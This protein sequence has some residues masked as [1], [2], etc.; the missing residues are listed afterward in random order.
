MTPRT[1]L[2][3]GIEEMALELPRTACERLLQ[4]IALLAKWNRTYNLTAIRDPLGMVEQHLLDSLAVLPHLPLP[5][6]GARVADAGSGAGLPGLPL[7]LA[8]PQ[9]RVALLEANQK[10]AA[11]LRQV[12]IELTLDNVEVHAVRVES[13]QPAS[14]FALVISRA[15]AH[16]ADFIAA[17]RHLVAPGG[18]LAAMKGKDP[19]AEVAELPADV[20]CQR[21]VRVRPPFGDAERHLV[22][23]ELRA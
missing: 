20:R 16:L 21:I 9:W 22:L 4:Y 23:C 6:S 12:V 3:R 15:F 10:K 14:G 7:A 1:A 8:R 18:V 2:E 17:C 11:F 13:W 19:H 5:M